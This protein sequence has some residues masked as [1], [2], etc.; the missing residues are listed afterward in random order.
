MGHSAIRTAL[1]EA[2]PGQ[3]VDFLLAPYLSE[4]IGQSDVEM[5][6]LGVPWLE[7]LRIW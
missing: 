7:K 6:F 1:D 3:G 5:G 4:P 2:I